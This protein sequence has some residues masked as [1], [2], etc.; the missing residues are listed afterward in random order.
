MQGIYKLLGPWAEARGQK[1]S[2][3]IS[4]CQKSQEMGRKVVGAGI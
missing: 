3:C 1:R 2:S 4:P